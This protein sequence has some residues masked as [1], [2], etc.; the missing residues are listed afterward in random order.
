LVWIGAI[1]FSWY[2]W[3]W[4]MIVFA[5]AMWPASTTGA[6]VAALASIVPAYLSYRVL[7]NR[8]RFDRRYV[9]RRAIALV[10]TCAAV[11]LV[12]SLGLAASA[13]L[14]RRTVSVSA[15]A[16][17]VLPL[18]ADSGRGCA[19]VGWGPA[20]PPSCTF[21]TGTA[22]VHIALVGDSNAGQFTEPAARAAQR[23]GVDLTVATDNACPFADVVVESYG[24]VDPR[25]RSNLRT[26]WRTLRRNRPDLV[27]IANSSSGYVQS[28]NY[29][30]AE[31]ESG[32]LESSRHGKARVFR[33]A[34]ERVLRLLERD[35]IPAV[36]IHVI[37]HFQS[38]D[39]RTCP[40]VVLLLDTDGCARGISRRRVDA[41]RRLAIDA[42]RQAVERAVGVTAVDLVDDICGPR[43]CLTRR[44][45]LWLYRDRSHLSVHGA[46]TLADR[47]TEIVRQRLGLRR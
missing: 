1:S 41:D 6:A 26:T 15:A 43:R 21:G 12:A 32:S 38:F 37:P 40:A 20:L 46:L 29:R 47:F 10:V 2:L 3:H 23:L 24:Q 45:G 27:I 39:P 44:D 11:P 17:D 34:L 30:L 8:Y 28:D 14:E 4:P 7:E 35:G 9:G 42:E 5:R 25:C 22:D 33:R 19:D 18:H 16:D 36:V 31:G 13:E